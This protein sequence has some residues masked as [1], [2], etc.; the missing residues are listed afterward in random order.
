MGWF[1][2]SSIFN[3]FRD[4][5]NSNYDR[6]ATSINE[7]I[8]E[9]NA[10]FLQ[11]FYSA[12]ELM[13]VSKNNGLRRNIS[14]NKP[15]W[16]TVCEAMRNRKM[17]ALRL[18]RSIGTRCNLRRYITL[19]NS[20]KCLCREKK[21]AYEYQNRQKLVQARNT[22]SMFWKL[23]KE[24]A[25]NIKSKISPLQWYN[26]FK[27]L[28]YFHEQ[29]E[30]GEKN[31]IFAPADSADCWNDPFSV[32]EVKAALR[33]LK[34]GKSPG[35]D[36]LVAELFQLS[37]ALIAPLLTIFEPVHEKNNNLHRRKQS[38]RSASR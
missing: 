9:A 17:Q 18:F 11:V 29:D 3:K 32:S 37:S 33:K 36:G 6:I 16:D 14:S 34:S 8:E 15:W 24:N 10:M 23:L 7:N 12:A 21:R 38:R 31:I 28:F 1:K 30:N 19:R 4:T 27:E 20:F 5:L 2:I 25:E 35:S 22:P 13:K 26:Y